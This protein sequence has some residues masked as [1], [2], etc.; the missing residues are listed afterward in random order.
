M[1]ADRGSPTPSPEFSKGLVRNG[2]SLALAI[3]DH[4][5]CSCPDGAIGM[6]REIPPRA[7]NDCRST[8]QHRI[9][10]DQLAAARGPIVRVRARGY[11]RYVRGATGRLLVKPAS[12][13]SIKYT[14]AER[15]TLASEQRANGDNHASRFNCRFCSGDRGLPAFRRGA[16]L[17]EFQKAPSGR[18]L[19]TLSNVGRPM[20]SVQARRSCGASTATTSYQD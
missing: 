8:R 1:L 18:F 19:K 2:R 11:R 14:L 17:G 20:T 16:G 4:G 9:D 15:K 3:L 5:H 6:I 13:I 12:L 10:L 7:F